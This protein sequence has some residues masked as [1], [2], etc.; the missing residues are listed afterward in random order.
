MASVQNLTRPSHGTLTQ[1]GPLS[2]VYQ[3][4]PGF[5]GVDQYSFQYCGS[6][7]SSSGCATLKYTVQVQ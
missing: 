6:N 2:V 1:T 7:G 4:S 5:R 3:P